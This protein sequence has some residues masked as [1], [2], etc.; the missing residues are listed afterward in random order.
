MFDIKGLQIY[1]EFYIFAWYFML[2]KYKI[3]N[4]LLVSS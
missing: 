2:N 1:L 4:K 3:M